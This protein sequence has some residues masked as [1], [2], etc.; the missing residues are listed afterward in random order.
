MSTPIENVLD[1][2]YYHTHISRLWDPCMQK[3]NRLMRSYVIFNLIFLAIGAFEVA[4]FLAFF[5][6]LSQSAVLAF[7]VAIFFM[8]LF[9]YFVLKLYIQAK[10]PDQLMDLCD[11]YL[12]R[13]KAI[14]HYQEGIP[15]HHIALGNAAHKFAA[16]LHEKE[17]TYYTPPPFLETLGPTLERFSCFCHWK[18]LHRMKELLL[19]TAVNEH[20][21]VVKCEP[22][23]LEVHAS[24]ANA[25]VTLSS[26]YADPRK[27]PDFDEERYIP[28]EKYSK[29]MQ[30]KFKA[31]AE[32]AIEEF[33]ILNDY[34]PDDPW[35]HVQLA[36]SYHDLQMPKEEI[37]E[38]ETILGLRPNDK[39][40]LFKLGMLY[41]QQGMNA[42]GLRIYEIL[43]KTHYK[44]A[45]S[46]I[47]FYGSYE[48]KD[49][50]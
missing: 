50:E 39:D 18:D 13:C 42:K 36:Y 12:E 34:A 1:K 16:E 26:L 15:E 47:K 33:K 7:T 5:A 17:Y 31:T 40:T 43:Q 29:A 11:A 27:Y 2:Q 10:K 20:L 48:D 25:Y 37:R 21:K 41:F 38:Y 35:V 3:L 32:R 22:T 6:F 30:A 46:L 23:N 24:L 8:T 49:E 14:I 28:V 4:L 44:K 19:T 9:S 45:E